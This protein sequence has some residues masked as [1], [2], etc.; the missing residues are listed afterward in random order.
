MTKQEKILSLQT[1]V[2]GLEARLSGAV[3]EKRKNVAESYKDYLRLEIK[4]ASRSIEKL[5][6]DGK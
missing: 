4:K 1:Y 2:N 5:K 6:L 3:P